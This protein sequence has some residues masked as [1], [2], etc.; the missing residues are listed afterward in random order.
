MRM[1]IRLSTIAALAALLMPVTA[2]SMGPPEAIA[3]EVEEYLL[4]GLGSQ[5]TI[6]TTVALSNFEI[7]SNCDLNDPKN[8]GSGC[9]TAVPMSGLAGSVPA[10]PG[11]ALPVFIGVSNDGDVALTDIDG[12]FDYSNIQVWGQR[13]VD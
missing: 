11:N 10:L 9:Q 6:S 5:I 12:N 4:I 3:G 8:A 13:G 2:S 7:G 1:R